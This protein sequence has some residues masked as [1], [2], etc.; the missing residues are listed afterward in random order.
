MCKRERYIIKGRK[1]MNLSA[2]NKLTG[3]VVSVDEGAEKK[4]Q[5]L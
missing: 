3:K 2:R 5:Q 1:T 4:Q